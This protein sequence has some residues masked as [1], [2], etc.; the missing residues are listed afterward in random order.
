[1][2][3]FRLF[4]KIVKSN[5]LA[6]LLSFVLLLV[7]TIPL[8]QIARNQYSDTYEEEIVSIAVF[9][10]DENDPLSNHLVE[11]LENETDIV[12]VEEEPEAVADA[13]FN[14]QISY[15]LTIPDGFGQAILQ[16]QTP[17]PLERQTTS[18][19]ENVV[20]VNTILTTYLTNAQILSV[21][22]GNNPS[23]EDIDT[24]LD[25]LSASVNTNIDITTQGTIEGLTEINAFGSIYTTVAGY[26]LIATFITVFG[27]AVISL[28][29]REVMK[30]NRLG[31]MTQSKQLTQ[32]LLAGFSFSL[33]DWLILMMIGVFIFGFDIVFSDTGL[34][35]VLSSFLSM[36][37][38]Q[39]F[40][41]FISTIAPNK[42]MIQF[43][44]NFLSL[45]LSFASGIFVP[46]SFLPTFMQHIASVVTPI[47]QVRANELI[48]STTNY[49][50]ATWQT[51]WQ[52]FGIMI[53][54]TLA[55]YAMSFVI[56]T[57]RHR[58]NVYL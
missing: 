37:G 51:I 54:I 5:M 47:W 12:A 29:Q 41:Y 6:I 36:L 33:L 49:S 53:L 2:P 4:Y 19:P 17:I 58:Q 55:Y 31:Q 28:R 26:G 57:Y 27:Y 56:Q 13:L 7:F 46:R 15:A 44:S 3:V 32:L 40:A 34:L 42:G 50:A 8:T 20:A 23:N 48:L 38:I 14:D 30:R 43:L 25:Q 21:N 22:L 1:M 9:N 52:Y 18:V 35:I 39:A 11:Y 24:V 16:Q 45:F 10:H